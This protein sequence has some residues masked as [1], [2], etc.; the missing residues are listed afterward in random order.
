MYNTTIP[1]ANQ[2][3][4]VEKILNVTGSHEIIPKLIEAGVDSEKIAEDELGSLLIPIEYAPIVA[5]HCPLPEYIVVEQD[6]PV[7]I[8]Q[9]RLQWKLRQ[10]NE[11]LDLLQRNF[12]EQLARYDLAIK[13]RDYYKTHLINDDCLKESRNLLQL[14]EAIFVDIEKNYERGLIGIKTTSIEEMN[15][16]LR[17]LQ[18]LICL[19]A[20][21]NCGKTVLTVQLILEALLADENVCAIMLSLE[22]DAETIA[23]RLYRLC[24]DLTYE[25]LRFKHKQDIYALHK[26]KADEL[27]EKIASRL[28]IFDEQDCHN[29]TGK[30]LEKTMEALKKRSGCSRAIVG[31]DY[32][33]IWPLNENTSKGMSDLDR[34]KFFM[35]EMKVIRKRFPNDAIIII[36]EAR[37]PKSGEEWASGLADISGSGRLGF[38]FDISMQINPV[39]PKAI[40]KLATINGIELKGDKQDAFVNAV[41]EELDFRGV[42]LCYL[43]V[44][45][46]RDGMSKFKVLLQ[47]NYH[48]DIFAPTIC[49]NAGDILEIARKK[50]F[51]NI[52]DPKNT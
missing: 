3:F 32:L 40:L 37:K 2:V 14:K 24:S 18:K 34:D 49:L 44:N 10:V 15:T 41:Y 43:I 45:K 7:G 42:A 36:A 23:E 28:Q 11:E 8:E 6:F 35:K 22:M 16:K 48:K 9:L 33:Q 46:A 20:G 1:S 19:T 51:K 52:S 26:K 4:P 12:P 30:I 17:G 31:I 38:G 21:P 5:M 47:L 50:I 39:G 25:E 27:F 29:I 13:R